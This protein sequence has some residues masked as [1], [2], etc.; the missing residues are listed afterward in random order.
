[1]AHRVERIDVDDEGV[2][3][4]QHSCTQSTLA[5]FVGGPADGTLRMTEL[6]ECGLPLTHVYVADEDPTRRHMYGAF[7]GARAEYRYLGPLAA[8]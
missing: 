5:L 8:A 4:G 7:C 6:D 3:S 2:E 1:M